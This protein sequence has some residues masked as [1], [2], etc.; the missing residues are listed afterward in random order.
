[1]IKHNKMIKSFV[2]GEDQIRLNFNSYL[3]QTE[4]TKIQTIIY[5]SII[6][7]HFFKIIQ[8]FAQSVWLGLNQKNVK[9]QTVSQKQIYCNLLLTKDFVI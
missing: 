7:S 2:P 9:S 1:V 8:C 3:N 5:R 6:A 4:K